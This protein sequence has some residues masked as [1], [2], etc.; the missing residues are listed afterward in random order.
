M[1]LK[2]TLRRVLEGLEGLAPEAGTLPRGP[3][4]PQVCKGGPTLLYVCMRACIIPYCG[5]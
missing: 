5:A 3:Y 2:R 1:E 4:R